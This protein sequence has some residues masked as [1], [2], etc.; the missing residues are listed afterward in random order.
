[1]EVIIRGTLC[2]IAIA[3]FSAAMVEANKMAAKA[4]WR[5]NVLAAETALDLLKGVVDSQVAR[6]RQEAA[7][8]EAANSKAADSESAE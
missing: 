2:G 3:G 7:N 6:K 8:S 1:M 5:A 4:L